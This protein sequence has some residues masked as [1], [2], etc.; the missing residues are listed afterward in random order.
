[1]AKTAFE[2][3]SRRRNGLPFN[4]HAEVAPFQVMHLH[5]LGRG[6]LCMAH[7]T[8]KVGKNRS[9]DD[10]QK[11]VPQ[12]NKFP[13]VTCSKT[14]G[15]VLRGDRLHGSGPHSLQPACGVSSPAS[16]RARMSGRSRRSRARA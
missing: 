8:R 16:T 7:K 13:K 14:L 3:T 4:H 10:R 15:L 2:E 12:M 6:G 1:M 11:P 9:A 5:H